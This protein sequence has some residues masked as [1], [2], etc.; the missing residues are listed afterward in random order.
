M[1]RIGQI[2]ARVVGWRAPCF[3]TRGLLH[4][5]KDVVRRFVQAAANS[6]LGTSPHCVHECGPAAIA[7]GAM[8]PRAYSS[9][10]ARL[11]MSVIDA[12]N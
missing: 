1:C 2:F 8:A 3:D 5:Y 9:R 7:A 11:A 12:M 4:D 6:I 10:S